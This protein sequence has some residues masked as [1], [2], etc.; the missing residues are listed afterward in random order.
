MSTSCLYIPTILV[1]ILIHEFWYSCRIFRSSCR[2]LPNEKN[3]NEIGTSFSW[4]TG[5]KGE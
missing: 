5:P 1:I 4:N 3:D 2:F